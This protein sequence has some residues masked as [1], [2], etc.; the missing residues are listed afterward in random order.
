L[1][2]KCAD[3][4]LIFKTCADTYQF[5][6]LTEYDAIKALSGEPVTQLLDILIN[7]DVAAYKKFVAA[8]AG[9]F[10]A[11]KLDQNLCLRKMRL[12]TLVTLSNNVVCQPSAF[13]MP[14]RAF[15]SLY[16]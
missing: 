1:V 2:F 4:R 7:G 12:L 3:Y 9:F 16:K 5:D 10:E 6:D 11:N 13:V 15:G 8:N 14:A